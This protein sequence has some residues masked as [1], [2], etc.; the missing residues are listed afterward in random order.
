MKLI[1]KVIENDRKNTQRKTL[2]MAIDDARNA[3]G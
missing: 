3:T 1:N 2:K